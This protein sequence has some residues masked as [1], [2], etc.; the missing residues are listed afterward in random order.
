[1][2]TLDAL[3]AAL[4]LSRVDFVKADIEGYEAALIAGARTTLKRCRPSLL[5][6]HDANHLAR[7]GSSLGALWAELTSL[8]YRPHKL[9]E[10]KVNSPQCKQM[11]QCKVTCFGYQEYDGAASPA[12][13]RSW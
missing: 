1:V 13:R 10:W 2:T 5:L 7:T 12:V 11:S 3:I 9:I 6:E 4:Q 8:G